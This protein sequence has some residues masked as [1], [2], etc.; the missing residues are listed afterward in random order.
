[1]V[2]RPG[3]ISVAAAAASHWARH[4]RVRLF[5]GLHWPRKAEAERNIEQHLRGLDK[6][7]FGYFN[8]TQLRT[9]SSSMQTRS[10]VTS[11]AQSSGTRNCMQTKTRT[12]LSCLPFFKFFSF[13]SVLSQGRLQVFFV[14]FKYLC[15]VR[16]WSLQKYVV[17]SLVA[18][19]AAKLICKSIVSA[20]SSFPGKEVTMKAA[21]H[22]LTQGPLLGESLSDQGH[23]QYAQ[24]RTSP[25][26][27][28]S[29]T[30]ILTDRSNGHLMFKVT[31]K[32]A[33]VLRIF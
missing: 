2:S 14:L 20:R 27:C 16:F 15:Y 10:L 5:L 30:S 31:E 18:S 3:S 26:F 17:H 8:N 11:K 4:T 13:T 23:K 7:R 24:H 19:L 32:P 28:L 25:Q 22:T 1:M 33:I 29:C 21:L 12:F 9:T 6:S